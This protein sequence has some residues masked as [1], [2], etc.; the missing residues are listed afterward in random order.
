MSYNLARMEE[1]TEVKKAVDEAQQ[2][3]DAQ[4]KREWVEWAGKT[5]MPCLHAQ[6]V[7]EKADTEWVEL[8]KKEAEYIKQM[9]AKEINED[10]F[11]ELTGE[12]DLERA[13]GESVTEG[14]ATMQ[15]M[16]QDEEIGK[17]EREESMEEEPAAAAI[18][19]ES[20]TI[21]KG[22]RKAAPTR[23]KVYMEVEGPVSSLTSH[24]QSVLTCLLTV[25]PMFHAE[26]EAGLHHQLV[27]EVVQEMPD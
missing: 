13:M 8:D 6:I 17:S 1:D 7:M 2:Y 21:G 27:R 5:L 12:L 15:A 20:S 26:D 19:V 3:Y 23:A 9:N 18:A 16:T 4:E 14:P 10:R 11:R 24:C 25:R 22:K